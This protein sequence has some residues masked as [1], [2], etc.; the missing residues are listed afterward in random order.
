MKKD[1]VSNIQLQEMF[2]AKAGSKGWDRCFHGTISRSTD[3]NGNPIVCG[4]IKINDGFIY[5]KASDQW[6][7]GEML[8]EMVLM[9]LD[10]RINAQVGKTITIREFEY[11]LN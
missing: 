11:Y 8:D 9:V 10:F 2:M 3:E 6:Q 5:A 4:K 7:L 1:R